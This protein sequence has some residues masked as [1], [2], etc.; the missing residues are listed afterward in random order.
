VPKRLNRI[1]RLIV[2]VAG[3]VVIGGSA[4]GGIALA[5]N[6]TDGSPA[7]V[8]PHA[9]PTRSTDDNHHN[10]GTNRS[11]SDSHESATATP[12]TTCTENGDDDDAIGDRQADSTAPDD[13]AVSGDHHGSD[14]G[15]HDGRDHD[16]DT[17]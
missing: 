6:R 1:T 11:T 13:D 16:C 4:L 5:A 14:D 2:M 9:T 8:S 17:D 3:L 15:D 7:T 12:T 10:N